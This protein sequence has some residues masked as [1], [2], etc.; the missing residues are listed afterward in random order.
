MPWPN[1]T[2]PNFTDDELVEAIEQ[3]QHSSDPVTRQI[4]E[5]CI[6]EWERRNG[7]PTDDD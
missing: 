2:I 3:H 7:R 4:T 6:R 5:G 1:K